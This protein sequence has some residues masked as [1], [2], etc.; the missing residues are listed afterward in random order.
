M[1]D[2]SASWWDD[3]ATDWTVGDPGRLVDILEYAYPTA[4]EVRRIAGEA[5]VDVDTAPTTAPARELWVWVLGQ[6]AGGVLDLAAVVLHDAASAHFH[7]PLRNLLGDRLGHVNARIVRKHGLPPVPS[8][9]P[10]SVV[11]SIVAAAPEI[12]AAPAL[13]AITSVSPAQSN[14]RARIQAPLDLIARTAMIE[15]AGQARG[16]GFLVG[17]DLLL[18]AAHVFDAHHWPPEPEREAVAV[19]DFEYTAGRSYAETGTRV[20]VGKLLAGSLPTPAEAAGTMGTNWDAP[21]DRLDFALLRLAGPAP[22]RPG[23]G[24]R[25]HYR[26]HGDDYDFAGNA[27]YMIMGF[28]LGDFLAMTDLTSS[29]QLSPSGTRIRYGGNTLPGASGSAVVDVRGRLVA[30]HHHGGQGRNQ[31]IPISVITRALLAGEYAALFDGNGGGGLTAPGTVAAGALAADPFETCLVSSGKPFVNRH[32]LRKHMRDMAENPNGPRTLAIQGESG[33]GVSHSYFLAAHVADRSLLCPRLREVSPAGMKALR[34]DLRS[35]Y[36]SYSVDHVRDKIAVAILK[37]LGVVESSTDAMAQEARETLSLVSAVRSR[38]AGSDE[39]WWLFFDSIDD[40]VAVQQGEIDELIRAMVDLADD[41]QVPLRVVLGGRA[42][43]AF[44]DEHAQW[45]AKDFA[46]GL[47][48]GEVEGW[49]RRRADQQ[50]RRIAE[51]TLESR[52]SSLFPPGQ[53]PQPRKLA[54]QL[55][56]LELEVLQS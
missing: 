22:E 32:D 25:G 40:M 11:D 46:V 29:P 17:D 47:P 27:N 2:D 51:S 41:D 16:T 3:P 36:E 1:S 42:A 9:G 10:D 14:P 12:G 30:I 54:L 6:C 50:N 24:S 44:A 56:T 13:Q 23:Q 35:Y 7:T 4:A 48:R 37:G 8:V 18:T 19:F 31:G 53:L 34:L 38:L 26:L 5:G 28:N 45:A 33:T 21:Q 52:L 55:K 20:P 43:E 39:Q 49:L 15:I